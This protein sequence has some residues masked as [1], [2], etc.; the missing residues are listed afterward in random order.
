MRVPSAQYKCKGFAALGTS[1]IPPPQAQKQNEGVEKDRAGRRG[2]NKDLPHVAHP[3]QHFLRN[4]S[5]GILVV[6]EQLLVT[7]CALAEP[8]R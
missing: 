1:S 3:H 4:L 2:R 5:F 8:P 6:L 7:A